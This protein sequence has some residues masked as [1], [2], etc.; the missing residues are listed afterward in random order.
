MWNCQ[1]KMLCAG[2]GE[3]YFV[4]SLIFCQITSSSVGGRRRNKDR[5]KKKTLTDIRKTQTQRQ[6]EA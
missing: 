6:S 4:Q 1:W 5:N 2:I 3:R